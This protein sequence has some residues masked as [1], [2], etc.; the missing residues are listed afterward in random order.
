MKILL[1]VAAVA[2][3]YKASGAGQNFVSAMYTATPGPRMGTSLADATGL[4]LSDAVSG[5]PL[6]NGCQP[7]TAVDTDLLP[8]PCQ[9]GDANYGEFAPNPAALANATFLD[10][11]KFIGMDTIQ[12]SLRNSSYDIRGNPPVR[13]CKDSWG[14]VYQSV[15]EP[16]PHRKCLDDCR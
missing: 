13:K 11:T 1:I 6:P 4:P 9:T 5:M 2:V 15:I 8:K 16:D 14:P 7:P 10:P 3:L 12:G